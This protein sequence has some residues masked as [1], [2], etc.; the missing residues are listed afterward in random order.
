M[1]AGPVKEADAATIAF[2]R[3]AAAPAR[4][5]RASATRRHMDKSTTGA[6]ARIYKPAKNPMQSGRGARSW[7]LEFDPTH[8]Q[9]IDAL[10]GWAGRGDVEREYSLRFAT[11]EEAVAYA[12]RRGLNYVVSPEHRRTARPP[13]YAENF[14]YRRKL[15]GH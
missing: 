6:T 10:M 11:C 1:F 7:I 12:E 9:E 15:Y 4:L 2:A 14:S 3:I 5:W 13:S 8:R